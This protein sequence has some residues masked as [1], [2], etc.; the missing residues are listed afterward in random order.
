MYFVDAALG[1]ENEQLVAVGAKPARRDEL[2]SR[3]I[4][5]RLLDEVVELG[6]VRRHGADRILELVVELHDKRRLVCR[7]RH[8]RLLE[9]IDANDGRHEQAAAYGLDE[10]RVAH[11]HVVE[12]D[13]IGVRHVEVV[14]AGGREGDAERQGQQLIE[15]HARR[16]LAT[17]RVPI[18][19]NYNIANDKTSQRVGKLVIAYQMMTVSSGR[20]VSVN[21]TSSCVKSMCKYS[22]EAPSSS[23]S[24]YKQSI[25]KREEE[26]EPNCLPVSLH[27]SPRRSLAAS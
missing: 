15:R 4:V 9:H 13:L 23:Q 10:A 11:L 8:A 22:I 16:L 20:P 25:E 21:R 2:V 27:C 14:P 1:G 17:L 24:H 3:P 7:R 26:E 12:L 5:E 19:K 6:V 18:R